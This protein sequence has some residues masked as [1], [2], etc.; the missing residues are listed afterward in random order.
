MAANGGGFGRDGAVLEGRQSRIVEFAGDS[1][2]GGGVAG[3]NHTITNLILNYSK[4]GVD[5]LLIRNKLV[6]N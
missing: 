6:L 3:I 1:T 2:T 5:K 4:L